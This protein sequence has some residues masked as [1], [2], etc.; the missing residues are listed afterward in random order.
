MNQKVV[1]KIILGLALVGTVFSGSLSYIELTGGACGF[2][3]GLPSCVYGFF[4]YLILLVLATIA[5][6]GKRK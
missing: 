4:M 3:L 2:I 1:L 6:K 5:L